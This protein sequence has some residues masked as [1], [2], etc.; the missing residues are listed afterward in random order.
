MINENSD[1][2]VFISGIFEVYVDM[3]KKLDS[4]WM[5]YHK[6]KEIKQI[7]DNLADIIL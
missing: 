1:K 4:L 3:L 5:L 2:K 6:D 7:V